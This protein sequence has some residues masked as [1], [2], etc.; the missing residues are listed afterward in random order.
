MCG[1]SVQEQACGRSLVSWC[2]GARFAWK[3]KDTGWSPLLSTPPCGPKSRCLQWWMTCLPHRGGARQLSRE[4]CPHLL[5]LLHSLHPPPRHVTSPEQGRASQR[6]RTPAPE[7]CAETQPSHCTC[8][9]HTNNFHLATPFLGEW[10]AAEGM[11]GRQVPA[12]GL[13]RP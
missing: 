7:P 6:G 10:R 13:C 11:S 8:S 12:G 2:R 9:S 5:S 4:S 3:R 1:V